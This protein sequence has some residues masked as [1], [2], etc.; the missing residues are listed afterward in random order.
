MVKA[1]IYDFGKVLLDWDPHHLYDPY[2]GSREKTDWFLEN[3]CTGL[4]NEK[5]DAGR[6]LAEGTEE[7]V[8]LHPEWEKEIRMF[9]GQW[10]KMI[11]EQTPG[12]AEFIKDFKSRGYKAYGLSNWSDETFPLVKDNFEVFSLMDGMVVSG[13]VKVAKPDP[14]I[15]EI[16]FEKFNLKPE[17]CIFIDDSPRNIAGAQKAGMRGIIFQDPDQA[18][19]E[20]EALLA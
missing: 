13:V 3:I 11:G 6:P 16:L 5:Q 7:L 8:S 12:M 18:R 20:L 2:F 1:I 14:R 15:Y 9:Y 4:W 19:R 17:E 10:I